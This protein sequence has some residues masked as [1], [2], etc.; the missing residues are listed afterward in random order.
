MSCDKSRNGPPN[1]QKKSRGQKQRTPLDW[2]EA[3]GHLEVQKSS[4][5]HQKSSDIIKNHQKSSNKSIFYQKNLG[6]K[7][8]GEAVEMLRRQSRTRLSA[9]LSSNTGFLKQARSVAD[10]GSFQ[11]HFLVQKQIHKGLS[12]PFS[13]RAPKMINCK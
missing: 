2:A 11:N 1:W 5:N 12:L 7:K 9:R 8:D 13:R 10:V 4:E 6:M 3:E